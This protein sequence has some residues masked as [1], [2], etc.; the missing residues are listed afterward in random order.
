[1]TITLGKKYKDRVTGFMGLAT[2]RH[3]Y[4]NGCVRVTIQATTLKEGKP[5]E[6]EAFDIEQLDFVDDGIA[7]APKKTGGPGDVPKPRFQPSE[8]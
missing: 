6:P 8:R 5:L 2:A 7:V 4:L 3:E 1:M